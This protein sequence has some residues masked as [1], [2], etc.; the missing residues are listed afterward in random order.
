MK[1]DKLPQ[2]T[3]IFGFEKEKTGS[4]HKILAKTFGILDKFYYFC[5]VEI[6]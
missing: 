2:I 1:Q 3:I 6:K 5:P 4:K